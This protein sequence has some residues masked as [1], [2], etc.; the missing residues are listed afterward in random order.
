MLYCITNAYAQGKD[1]YKKLVSEFLDN[2]SYYCINENVDLAGNTIEF[3][4]GAVIDFRGGRISN[5]KIVI[6]DNTIT[7]YSG[8]ADDVEIDGTVIGPL[9]LIVFD[10]R[11][12]DKSY[13]I[14][15]VLN[16]TNRICKS[17]IV[18]EG[19]YYLQTPVV[20]ENIRFYEQFGDIIYNG[21]ATDLTVLRF[22]KALGAVINING[23]VACDYKT[24]A[25]NYTKDKR[26]NIIGVEFANIN[27]SKVYIGDVEYFNNNIRI[28]AYGAGNCYNQYT[29]NLSVFSNEHLRIFQKDKPSKQIGWCN[30][31]VFIGGRFCNWS[32]FD[33]NQCESVAIKIEGAEQDD[34][35]NG[36]NSLLFIKPCMEGFKEFAVCAKNVTGCHW[37]DVRTEESGG[38]IKFVGDCRYNK[39]NSLYGTE[40]IDYSECS[41]YPL[42][43][44][45]MHPILTITEN[46]NKEFVIDTKEAK[47]FR[48]IFNNSDAKARVGI[49][50]LT[51]DTGRSI[52]E[53][54][55]KEIIR[56][57]SSSYPFSYYYNNN[58][59]QWVLGAD[60]Y[61]TDFLIPDEV[62]RIRISLT[63]QYSGATI[64]SNKPTRIIE[65]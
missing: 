50:Y 16:K 24:G 60:S 52:N 43:L 36:A 58:V 49:R 53:N 35:Y 6:N 45:D 55:Q 57:R 11:R 59:A 1:S 41:T 2:H 40:K 23:K 33:W 30:E 44:K 14:G 20:L 64:Y 15:K 7:G 3:P 63:G 48:V 4:R 9:N 42:V 37:Q 29:I 25:V 47:I 10:L 22:F 5:G 26:S 8:I 34:S 13:D 65:K 21:K 19:S 62:T 28:S 32:H 61:E 12:N 38:F 27:N 31:N 56:P 18:P 46:G 51:D 39:A 54:A 17:V